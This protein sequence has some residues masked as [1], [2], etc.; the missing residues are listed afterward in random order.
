MGTERTL[1]PWY[2]GP[3]YLIPEAVTNMTDLRHAMRPIDRS[4]AHS[5]NNRGIRSPRRTGTEPRY[6][7]GAASIVTG[8]STTR[9][10]DWYSTARSE[11]AY[12][13]D[14]SSDDASDDASTNE[15]KGVRGEQA[16]LGIQQRTYTIGPHRSNSRSYSSKDSS[17]ISLETP[18]QAPLKSE[19]GVHVDIRHSGE[20]KKLPEP[21]WQISRSHTQELQLN[22]QAQSHKEHIGPTKSFPSQDTNFK[23]RLQASSLPDF[24]PMFTWVRTKNAAAPKDALNPR[25]VFRIL[26]RIHKSLSTQDKIYN[27]MYECT[28][29]ELLTRHPRTSHNSP[30]SEDPITREAPIKPRPPEADGQD[31]SPKEASRSDTD[32]KDTKK[33]VRFRN[34]SVSGIGI[35]N[36]PKSPRLKASNGFN[37]NS[38]RMAMESFVESSLALLSRFAIRHPIGSLQKIPTVQGYLRDMETQIED[39]CFV[40]NRFIHLFLPQSIFDHNT[41]VQKFWGSVEKIA[42]AELSFTLAAPGQTEAWSIRTPSFSGPLQADSLAQHLSTDCQRCKRADKYQSLLEALKHLHTHTGEHKH[43]STYEPHEDP[44]IVWLQAHHGLRYERWSNQIRPMVKFLIAT[45]AELQRK[46]IEFGE[47]CTR[48]IANGKAGTDLPRNMVF[49]FEAIIGLYCNVADSITHIN[50]MWMNEDCE[51]DH[52]L[53]TSGSEE[54][55]A[56]RKNFTKYEKRANTLLEEAH[57][58]AI[59]LE[60]LDAKPERIHIEPV[61]REFL[62]G[63]ILSNL[64]NRPL[65]ENS[66]MDAIGAFKKHASRLQYLVHSRP[67]KRLF[68]ELT[69]LETELEALRK[70]LEYQVTM[71]KKFSEITN[72]R[73]YNIVRRDSYA[74]YELVLECIDNLQHKLLAEGVQIQG[75]QQKVAHLKTQVL[76]ILEV[77]E[78][79]HGKAIRV[80][81]LVTLFFLPILS[82]QVS[83]A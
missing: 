56:W 76:Q 59:L 18:S 22:S 81:T 61:G 33:R 44:C 75:L 38:G 79:G 31:T 6:N 83:W 37:H 70:V 13:L 14:S 63:A 24:N 55:D 65:E 57:K 51:L 45:V 64:H 2:S 39:L 32:F 21:P 19:H 36:K 35:T 82:S 30:N 20:I 71:L 1:G 66:N 60:N 53:A 52:S 67:K 29:N 58:D 40:S 23:R 43:D 7:D 4:R 78:E 10:T 54:A 74:Q 80:F 50:S 3:G 62:L 15:D 47:R 12:V 72:P 73:S 49:A 42:R 25:N 68:I 9:H 48:P 77:L 34:L 41:V 16:I 5:S 11:A 28:L 8:A 46:A 26:T 17:S 69:T 27:S